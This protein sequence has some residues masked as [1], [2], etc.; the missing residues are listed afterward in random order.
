MADYRKDVHALVH[1]AQSQGFN[2]QITR[3]GYR[4]FAKSLTGGSVV[5][6]RTPS[7]WRAVKNAR[8]E[9]R[10]IGVKI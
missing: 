1:A 4:V 6:H 7:D 2:V 10:K 3:K 9:L 5:I 8:S